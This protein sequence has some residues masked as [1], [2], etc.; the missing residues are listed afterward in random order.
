[1]LIYGAV[2]L[3]VG[4]IIVITAQKYLLFVRTKRSL[5]W[6]RIAYG[7]YLPVVCVV[8]GLTFGGLFYAKKEL[9]R[10]VPDEIRRLNQVSFSGYQYTV[11]KNWDAIM[12]QQVP[13]DYTVQRHV[14]EIMF[15]PYNDDWAEGRKTEM[16]NGMAP[17]IAKWGI[18]G[19]VESQLQKSTVAQAA[20][21]MT[22][23]EASRVRLEAVKQV[24]LLAPEED[25]WA[26]ADAYT[27]EKINGYWQPFFMRLFGLFGVLLLLP[28]VETI[29]NFKRSYRK[30]A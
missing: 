17:H 20:S 21:E 2:G 8:A 22:E 28:F 25:F 5:K 6:L 9:V 14:D 3:V 30:A 29:F 11:I 27:V 10:Q 12:Q 1:M 13:F 18:E 7:I 26:A 16:A 23:E 19:I 4:L 15:E 24:D